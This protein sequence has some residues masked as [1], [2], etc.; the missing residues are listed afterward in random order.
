M[1]DKPVVEFSDLPEHEDFWASVVFGAPGYLVSIN[2]VPRLPLGIT[3]WN[4]D[5]LQPYRCAVSTSLPSVGCA[6][7]LSRYDLMHD[8]F[9]AVSL[10]HASAI[11]IAQCCVVYETGVHYRFA[12]FS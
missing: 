8:D 12:A 2:P 5:A 9:T 6:L 3:R 1:N 4:E 11:A 10:S 7:M